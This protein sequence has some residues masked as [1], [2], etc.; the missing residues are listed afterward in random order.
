MK[1][2]QSSSSLRIRS[3]KPIVNDGNSISKYIKNVSITNKATAYE[4]LRRLTSFKNF[5]S[6]AFDA[7]TVDELIKR[8]RE[9]N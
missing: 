1:P 3:D 9:C 8:I 2:N 6:N 5:I 7:L 4:Y